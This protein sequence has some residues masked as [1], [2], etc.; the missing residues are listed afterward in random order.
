MGSNICRLGFTP[1]V[2]HSSSQ[3]VLQTPDPKLST[4]DS[5]REAR[6][7]TP[8]W[9][10]RALPPPPPLTAFEGLASAVE[11]TV[12][13]LVFKVEGSGVTTRQVM[14]LSSY[15]ENQLFGAR[16]PKSYSRPQTLNLTPAAVH[17]GPVRRA[18]D[19]ALRARA[20][21]PSSFAAKRRFG[22]SNSYFFFYVESPIRSIIGH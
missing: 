11:L 15:F 22:F 20:A 21:H 9:P 14:S 3:K 19:G 16:V 5:T 4:R 7:S 18:V 2:A 8:P 13:G 17:A 12:Q 1:H 6:P 10:G